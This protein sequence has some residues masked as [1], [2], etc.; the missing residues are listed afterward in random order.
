MIAGVLLLYFLL[1]LTAHEHVA[2]SVVRTTIQDGWEALHFSGNSRCWIQ[3][4][5]V[6]KHRSVLK[7]DVTLLGSCT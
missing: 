2:G 7:F 6:A 3:S 4:G 5:C 1:E